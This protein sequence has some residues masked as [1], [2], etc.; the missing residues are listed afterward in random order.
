MN[1]K[2]ISEIFSDKLTIRELPV[3]EGAESVTI[4]LAD[5]KIWLIVQKRVF[6]IDL[7]G[8]RGISIETEHGDIVSVAP[9]ADDYVFEESDEV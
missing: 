7:T 6:E 8:L 1:K 2:P 4:K 9:V 5:H 3:D